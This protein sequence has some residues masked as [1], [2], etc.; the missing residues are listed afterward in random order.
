MIREVYNG[1][2]IMELLKLDSDKICINKGKR[3]F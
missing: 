1:T 2:K 3:E